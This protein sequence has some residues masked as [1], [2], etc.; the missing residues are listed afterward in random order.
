MAGTAA[1]LVALIGMVA[2][3]ACGGGGSGSVAAAGK[4]VF[5]DHC[6]ECHALDAAGSTTD[7]TVGPDL[8]EARPAYTQ[9][10]NCVTYGTGIMPAFGTQQSLTR[11][12]IREVATFVSG[13]TRPNKQPP[14]V[15]RC[16]PLPPPP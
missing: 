5:G 16:G 12:Q 4:S 14:P 10:V 15:L 2:L 13:A 11:D 8:D 3:S 7:S 9:V 1:P 6:A